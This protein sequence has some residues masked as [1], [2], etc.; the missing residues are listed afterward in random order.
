MGAFLA[1]YG[2]TIVLFWKV[3]VLPC[4][5]KKKFQVIV[6]FLNGLLVSPPCS[7][8]LPV[9][10]EKGGAGVFCCATRKRGVIVDRSFNR[11]FFALPASRHKRTESSTISTTR[12]ANRRTT[13]ET[14]G[15]GLSKRQPNSKIRTSTTGDR[16]TQS[17]FGSMK[18]LLQ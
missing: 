12:R 7:L 9:Q 15:C 8:L 17:K 13:R 6:Q 10:R 18:T 2:F 4:W 16:Q 3:A 5:P 11:Q 1:S 14:R